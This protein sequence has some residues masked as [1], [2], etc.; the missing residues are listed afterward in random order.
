MN[1][2]IMQF[3]D[4][5]NVNGILTT[6]VTTLILALVTALVAFWRRNNQLHLDHIAMKSRMQQLED[7]R[8]KKVEDRLDAFLG[9]QGQ[10]L[11]DISAL[12]QQVLSIADSNKRIED[13]FERVED[14]LLNT[15]NR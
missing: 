10:L 15:K 14:Y 1:N 12:K 7:V 13:K 5:L 3:T 6:L 8:I 9:Q 2:P 4:F 11:Q